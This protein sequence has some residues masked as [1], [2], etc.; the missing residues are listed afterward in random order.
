MTDNFRTC[1]I[2]SS[3]PNSLTQNNTVNLSFRACRGIPL[4]HLNYTIW[5][6]LC[7]M[8]GFFGLPQNDKMWE[9]LQE[10]KFISLN[11]QVL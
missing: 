8:K 2:G 10:S 9:L 1:V 3:L 11:A 7:V 4:V 5:I 6:S